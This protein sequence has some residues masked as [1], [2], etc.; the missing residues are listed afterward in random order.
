MFVWT[1]IQN[2]NIF[3][4]TCNERSLWRYDIRMS[5]TIC[6]LLVKDI[7]DYFSNLRT[8]ITP[9]PPPHRNAIIGHYISGTFY[10]TPKNIQVNEG[11]II[12]N[13][14]LYMIYLLNIYIYNFPIEK[15]LIRRFD[16][17]IHALIPTINIYVHVHDL[18]KCWHSLNCV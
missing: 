7:F 12:K 16:I 5:S 13:S 9:P 15:L 17:R 6:V 10:Y 8:P 3:R 18:K 11:T 4:K 14:F 1:K 2:K